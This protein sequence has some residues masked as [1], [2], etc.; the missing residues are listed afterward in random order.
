MTHTASHQCCISIA[1]DHPALPGHFPGHPLVPGVV[2]LDEVLSQARQW[3]G[4]PLQARSLA[5][6]KFSAP[7][8]PGQQA[9]LQ[10]TLTDN[11]LKFEIHSA[12]QPIA[13]G[14]FTLAEPTP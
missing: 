5:Q 1:A 10:L 13:Q 4:R 7:L 11:R 12:A 6:A 2:L 8:R 3:L 14:S 9:R